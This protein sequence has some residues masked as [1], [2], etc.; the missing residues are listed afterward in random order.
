MCDYSLHGIN[1][2]LA[3][4]GEKLIVHRFRT[5]SI[6]MAAEGDLRSDHPANK[7]PWCWLLG[8][9][10]RVA[11]CA[12]CIPPGAKL[13][14]SDIPLRLQREL[15][16]GPAEE[17][18]FTQLTAETNTYRDAVRFHNGAELL[19]QRLDVGQGVDVLSLADAEVLEPQTDI[20]EIV[21]RGQ[22]RTSG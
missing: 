16:V 1:N 14:L 20:S 10:A 8:R 9:P 17:V 12:V 19:L 6:G 13:L 4:E 11:S 21:A 22:G 2:R 7:R 3:V 5:G 18:M 15:G